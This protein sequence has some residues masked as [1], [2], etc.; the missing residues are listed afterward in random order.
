ML[1]SFLMFLFGWILV[2]EGQNQTTD[3]P[4]DR[5]AEEE[6]EEWD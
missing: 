4:D 3:Q 2:Q 6:A 5:T 1:N